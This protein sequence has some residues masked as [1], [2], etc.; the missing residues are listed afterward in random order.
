M[1]YMQLGGVLSLGTLNDFVNGTLIPDAERTIDVHVG[2]RDGTLRHFNPHGTDATPIT[3]T[4]DGNAKSVLFV[5]PR[6][7]PLIGLGTVTVDDNEVTISNIKVHPQ[8]IEYD[9]GHF[10]EG[11]QNI[12]LKGSYGY[13][14]VPSEIQL[15]AAQLCSNT[16]LN[17]A[18]RRLTDGIPQSGIAVLAASRALLNVPIIFTDDMREKLKSYRI[19]WVDLG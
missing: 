17:V 13:A 18:R 6:Y 3:V 7:C 10:T 8:F 11:K 19:K 2:R 12:Q 5:P 15:M 14:S 16:L 9:G 1:A 4:L